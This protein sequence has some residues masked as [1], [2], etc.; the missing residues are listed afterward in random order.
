MF[1]LDEILNFVPLY[2]IKIG[3]STNLVPS[4][5]P[6]PFHFVDVIVMT[7][8]LLLL[9]T[10]L[11]HCCLAVSTPIMWEKVISDACRQSS[12][13][14]KTRHLHCVSDKRSGTRKNASQWPMLETHFASTR[15]CCES[16]RV[17]KTHHWMW[18]IVHVYS[19]NMSLMRISS[20]TP[21]DKTRLWCQFTKK[22]SLP[23]PYIPQPC[24][25]HFSNQIL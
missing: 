19:Q 1:R 17:P 6:H 14:P 10:C 25:I 22:K 16:T 12:M 2:Y 13:T 15:H 5:C 23:G 11:P 7:P 18:V 20:V 21:I 24:Y 8:C 3:E 9:L 4:P